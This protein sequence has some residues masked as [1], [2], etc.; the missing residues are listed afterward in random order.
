MYLQNNL[1]REMAAAR[2]VKV[3]YNKN[4]TSQWN[5]SAVA[6]V[7]G[8]G[9]RDPRQVLLTHPDGLYPQALFRLN[10]TNE[11]CLISSFKAPVLTPRSFYMWKGSRF[12]E[13]INMRFTWD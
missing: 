1:S 7:I 2:A 5:Y 11:L 13:I 10:Y 3:E 6:S 12:R 4:N 8:K 9:E